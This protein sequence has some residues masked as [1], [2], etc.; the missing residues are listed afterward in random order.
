MV[1]AEAAVSYGLR[2][3]NSTAN[4]DIPSSNPVQ[5]IIASVRQCAA[6]SSVPFFPY[7]PP[8]A[9]QGE[10]RYARE[11]STKGSGLILRCGNERWY[12]NSNAARW[13]GYQRNFGASAS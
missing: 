12:Q 9:A 1:G 13:E 2:C 6:Q 5:L 8:H 10:R 11:G 3:R 4:P 7:Y